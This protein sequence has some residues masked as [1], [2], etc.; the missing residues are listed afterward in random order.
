MAFTIWDPRWIK[1]GKK[2]KLARMSSLTYSCLSIVGLLSYHSPET[3]EPNDHRL[4]SVTMSQNESFLLVSLM[5]LVTVT[6][7]RQTK[8]N[9][10]N[11]TPPLTQ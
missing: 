11:A 10:Q 5:D 7:G 2:E 6:K 8:Q 3:V 4:T 9:K 1:R